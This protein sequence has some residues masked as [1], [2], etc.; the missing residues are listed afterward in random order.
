MY[1][2]AYLFVV[3]L[4]DDRGG[5]KVKR[6]YLHKIEVVSTKAFWQM[7]AMTQGAEKYKIDKNLRYLKLAPMEILHK[8]FV[9]YRYFTHYYIADLSLL[10]SKLPFGKLKSILAEILFEELGNGKAELAHPMLYDNFL[11]SIGV[12]ANLLEKSDPY[13]I[14]NLNTIQQ[15]LIDSSWA[16]GVGL[17]GMGGECLCH[18]YLT[19]LYEFFSENPTVKAIK[20]DVDWRFWDIHIGEVDIHHQEILRDA[21]NEMI[22]NQPELGKDLINGYVESKTAWD[23]YWKQIF[24]AAN[25]N[26]VEC[27]GE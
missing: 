8:I 27:E 12:P 26:F 5:F 18:I 6:N 1:V 13:C 17:R 21:I 15:S 24:K 14:Q 4:K 20:H 19:T 2:K 22:T 9:Q 25:S 3:S 10:I 11:T 23:N 16:Y 7:A